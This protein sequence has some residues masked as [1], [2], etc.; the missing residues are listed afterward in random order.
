MCSDGQWWIY[1]CAMVDMFMCRACVE[2]V[3]GGYVHVY[4][5]CRAGQWWICSCAVV[6]NG[7]YAHVQWWSMVDMLRCRAGH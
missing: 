1:S 7:G 2:L 3:N 5:M 4:S 6:A